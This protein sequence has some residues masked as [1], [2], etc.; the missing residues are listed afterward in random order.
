MDLAL[1]GNDV[2]VKRNR[3]VNNFIVAYA[4]I[5]IDKDSGISLQGVYFGGAGESYEEAEDLARE[6]VNTTRGGTVL[7]KVLKVTGK[8]QVIDALYD[9][10]DNF[11]SI[12]R[13]MQEAD[14]IIKR[15]QHRSKR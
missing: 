7:P 1:A 5:I 12:T 10:A 4:K 8:H 14:G 13:Q 2:L 9:A 15:T 11:E 6:C 3:P